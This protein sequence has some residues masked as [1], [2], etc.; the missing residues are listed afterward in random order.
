MGWKCLLLLMAAVMAMATGAWLHPTVWPYWHNN[1]KVAPLEYLTAKRLF[2]LLS[3]RKALVPVAVLDD[4]GADMPSSSSSKALVLF[5]SGSSHGAATTSG[6]VPWWTRFR[7]VVERLIHHVW[8]WDFTLLSDWEKSLE[9]FGDIVSFVNTEFPKLDEGGLMEEG[10]F[11][12]AN[13]K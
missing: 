6:R 11:G 5:S 7:R 2:P 10:R 1:N 3:S 12:S 8:F 4:H 9:L 13:A